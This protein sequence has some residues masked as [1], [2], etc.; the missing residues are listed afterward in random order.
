MYPCVLMGFV[1]VCDRGKREQN[2]SFL[3]CLE[4]AV[5]NATL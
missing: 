4:N 2:S 3:P 5:R 1:S